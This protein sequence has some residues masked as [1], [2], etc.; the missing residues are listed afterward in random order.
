MY[1][2]SHNVFEIFAGRH[3]IR[4]YYRSK[5]DYNMHNIFEIIHYT[6][7]QKIHSRMHPI[8]PYL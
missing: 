1:Y 5:S 4:D 7:I 2:G 6:V 8:E 3:Y